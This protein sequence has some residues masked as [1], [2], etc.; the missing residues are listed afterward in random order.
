MMNILLLGGTGAMGVPLVDFLSDKGNMLFVTSRKERSSDKKNVHYI[1]GNALDDTFLKTTLSIHYDAIVDFMHYHPDSFKERLDILLSSTDHYFFLSSCRTYAPSNNVITEESPL[2]LDCVKD[3][4]Y[5]STN[6]Y[7]L[8]KARCERL[9]NNSGFSNWTIIRPYITYNTERLQLSIFEKEGWLYRALLGHKIVFSYD[10]AEKKTTLT[11]G[12][13]VA[14]AISILIEKKIGCGE[15]YQI[16]GD[17][18]MTWNEILYI[19]CDT[20]EE[21]TGRRPEIVWMN[22][23]HNISLFVGNS[24]K[25]QYDRL[26][27]RVFDNSKILKACEGNFSFIPI[28]DGLKNCLSLFIEEKGNFKHIN[29]GLEAYLDRLSKDNSLS[30]IKGAKNLLKYFLVRYTP[31]YYK[32]ILSRQKYW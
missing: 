1:V 9:L 28:K 14:R 10:L 22:N 30:S 23:S 31:A 7:A 12:A 18:F 20:I 21:K 2:L 5:L 4:H 13:D 15:T 32:K 27:D 11:Y 24:Y 17:D 16:T 25:T 29:I 8:S 19:Y 6:E 26:T 3:S